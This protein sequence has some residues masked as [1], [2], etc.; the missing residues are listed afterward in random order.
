MAL[1][2]V[3]A[4]AVDLDFDRTFNADGA[5]PHVY[6]QARYRNAG[7]AHRLEVWREGDS[8]LKRR[9][10]ERIE[11]IVSRQAGQDE[12][13]M[14]VLDLLHKRRTDIDRT[15]L[16]RIGHFTDW[17]SQAHAL[18]RPSG[19]YGLTP[20]QAAPTSVAPAASCDW[21]VLRTDAR[22]DAICWSVALRLPMLIAD[23]H[24]KV[25][26]QVTHVATA[27]F[28]ADVFAIHDDGF[29]R[30]NANDDIQAD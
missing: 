22:Q 9:T 26:W 1:V 6:F 15:N 8:R 4:L 27:A 5:P 25:Q 17:F 13:Q 3:P 23:A 24:G 11:T 29:M 18:T 19:S 2:G 20:L 30:I 10:D 21:F 16:L 28:A 12:W 7:G 14:V